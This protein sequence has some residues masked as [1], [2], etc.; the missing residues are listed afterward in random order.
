[1][2]PLWL[3]RA[4]VPGG[5]DEIVR[6]RYTLDGRLC[7]GSFAQNGKTY[8]DCTSDK[9]PDNKQENKEWCYVEK[10]QPVGEG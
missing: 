3:L 1:L 5:S 4:A 2:L 7:A 8:S 10:D 9:S 6:H